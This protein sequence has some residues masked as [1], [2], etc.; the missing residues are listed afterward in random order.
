MGDTVLYGCIHTCDLVNYCWTEKFN[1]G[2][3]THFLQLCGLKSSRNSSRLKNRRCELS[4]TEP[5]HCKA[6]C[7]LRSC[8]CSRVVTVVAMYFRVATAQ[9]K[10]GI[11]KSI[12]PDRK[13]QGILSWWERG[14][15]VFVSLL[16]LP[17]ATKLWPRLCFYTCLCFCPWGGLPQCM[18]GYCHHPSSRRRQPPA[19][20]IP[21]K[22]TP[23]KE[24][25][26]EGDP[27]A[28]ETP[29]E[30][31]TSQEGGTPSQAD[32]LERPPCQG[33]PPGRRHPLRKETPQPR[34]PPRRPPKKKASPAKE[35]PQGGTPCQGDPPR[36]RHSPRPTPQG[37]IEGDQ[38]QA[39]TQG[40][41][42][43]GIR[44]R[45]TPKGE[46]E[47]G[48]DPGLHPRGKLRGIRS[49]PAPKGGNWGAS[50]PG[51]HP[52][53]KLGGSDPAP[54]PAYGQWAAGTHPTGIHSCWKVTCHLRLFSR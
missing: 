14:S 39:H 52:R 54:P 16:S 2:L 37:E 12:F 44:Y 15:P 45:P 49:R 25:P 47:G 23:R 13:T 35:T 51:P 48:S 24:T 41:N 38:I 33:D 46:I 8:C 5:L 4:L 9:R 21:Q 1:N 50:D 31:C 28:K 36:R 6:T 26:L 32:P 20:E 10:Q 11:W 53:G 40:G 7:I 43:G 18:L 27:P 42:W 29:Q 19:K 30:E 34:R 17:A 3:C 22:E